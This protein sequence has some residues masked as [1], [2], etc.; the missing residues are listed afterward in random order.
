MHRAPVVAAIDAGGRDKIGW[1]LDVDGT[2][3]PTTPVRGRLMSAQELQFTTD[4]DQWP[5]W[6]FRRHL[7]DPEEC[8]GQLADS[9]VADPFDVLGFTASAFGCFGEDFGLLV[10]WLAEHEPVLQDSL[11]AVAAAMSLPIPDE[12]L[13][14]ADKADDREVPEWLREID[15]IECTGIMRRYD[16]ADRRSSSYLIETQLPG[17]HVS[18]ARLSLSHKGST[19][20]VTNFWTTRLSLR[21]AARFYR[22]RYWPNTTRP[23]RHVK[24]ETACRRI[25]DALLTSLET[26]QFDADWEHSTLW[27]AN[28]A[29]LLL[30]LRPLMAR[31]GDDDG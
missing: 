2:G 23:Y 1:A 24:P 22:K 25:I 3:E 21:Q 20:R 15:Q 16:H 4:D 11:P 31:P 10:E 30:V 6:W 19:D 27:P 28:V 18:T 12:L 7:G 17:G 14:L 5:E 29:V 26:K 8:A 9:L 13:E